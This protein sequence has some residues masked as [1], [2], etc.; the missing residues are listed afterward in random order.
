METATIE[1]SGGEGGGDWFFQPAS[2]EIAPGAEVTWR[3]ASGAA[4]TVTGDAL[5]FA[6]SGVLDPGDSFSQVFTEPG[7]YHFRCGPH[8]WMTGTIV[9]RDV[10]RNNESGVGSRKYESA[11]RQGIPIADSR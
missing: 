2:L 6:D 8:P 10:S 7:T 4:H 5:A 1:I 3:N 9:V 11:S